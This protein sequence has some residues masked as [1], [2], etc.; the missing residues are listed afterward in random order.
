M[1][2]LIIFIFCFLFY[3][4]LF[5]NASSTLQQQLS[6]F[7]SMT[8][9]FSEVVLSAD[10]SQLQSSNGTMAI[11]RPGKFRWITLQPMQQQIITDGKTVWV[12]DKA[13]AQVIVRQLNQ[14][15]GQ[16][17][18]LLL[19]QT[20]V[21]LNHQFTIKT[22]TN[23]EAGQWF[24]LTPIESNQMFSQ[25]VLGFQDNQIKEMHFSNQLS[26]E[27]IVKF[28]NIKINSSVS[29]SDFVFKVPQGVDVVNQ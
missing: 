23:K 14:S 22:L 21:Y 5:A 11:L 4:S 19:T 17:P 1:R 18:I 6:S 16:T 25:V 9:D 29:A 27:T 7:H 3:G 2:Q 26:Q 10:G 12:Y 8:A 28:S 24:L 15:I 20:H 13:L